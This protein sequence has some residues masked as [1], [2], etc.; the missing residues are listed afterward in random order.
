M[1]HSN[2]KKEVT[3]F[4]SIRAVA[5][6]SARLSDEI[7]SAGIDGANG[8]SV[9]SRDGI[10]EFAIQSRHFSGNQSPDTA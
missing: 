10:V 7:S 3:V 4:G 6:I 5:P 8:R 1:R 9:C 2:P